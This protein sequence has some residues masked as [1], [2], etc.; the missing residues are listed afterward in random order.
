MDNKFKDYKNS[1]LGL[2]PTD[3]KI[4]KLS[5]I[6]DF[7]NG[8]NKEKEYFGEG[9][10]IV[11]YVDVFKNRQINGADL[12]G[13]VRVSNSEINRFNVKDGD[14]FFTR[15]SETIHEIGFSSVIIN[16]QP[17]TVFSGFVLRA[18]EKNNLLYNLYKKYCFSTHLIRK[19]IITKS[20]KTTRALTSGTLLGDVNII[21]PPIAQQKKMSEII[22]TWDEAIDLQN[23]LITQKKNLLSSLALSLLKNQK[24]LVNFQSS[25]TKVSLNE[26]FY[27]RKEF[28]YEIDGLE[29]YSLTIEDGVTAKTDRY[30]REFLVKGDKKK[31]KVTKYH[32]LVFNPQN[33]RYGAIALNDNENPVLLSP[34]YV[35]LELKDTNK[36][37]IEYFNFLLT[38]NEMIKFY[39]SI[40]EGTLIE[41]MTVKPEIFLKQVF[42]IPPID[43]QRRISEVLIG[44]RDEINLLAKELELKKL[45]KKGLMQQLLTGKIRVSVN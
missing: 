28:G 44:L 45:Q 29:L 6:F 15:T 43:E 42:S 13:K 23:K 34:I 36:H 8:L 18:R 20:S 26:V 39:D 3:W 10:P 27:E 21:V 22:A 11:N 7:K 12:I 32:D 30:N 17:N 24:S 40:A 9:Y 37:D 5:D 14:V 16:S 41:R 1:E 25:W 33:L 4:F 19:E 35:T 2:I 31:Y 38:S